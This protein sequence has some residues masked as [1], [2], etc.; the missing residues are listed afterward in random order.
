[1]CVEQMQKINKQTEKSTICYK[2]Y[3][4]FE[5]TLLGDLKWICFLFFISLKKISAWMECVHNVLFFIVD[6]YRRRRCG[7]RAGRSEYDITNRIL[8]F[9][10][11]YPKTFKHNQAILILNTRAELRSS[12][13]EVWACLKSFIRGNQQRIPTIWLNLINNKLNSPTKS[14]SDNSYAHTYTHPYK[15]AHQMEFEFIGM[16]WCCLLVYD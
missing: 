16:E 13:V 12:C 10:N 1:M 15:H 8:N 2:Y 9:G 6:C 11:K 5:S 4:V 7:G 3:A 14:L